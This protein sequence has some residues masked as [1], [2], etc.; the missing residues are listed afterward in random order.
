MRLDQETQQTIILHR[1][2]TKKP[3]LFP[4]GKNQAQPAANVLQAFLDYWQLDKY[5][6]T[7]C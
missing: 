6:V 7:L 5:F 1:M 2:R 4:L 3:R